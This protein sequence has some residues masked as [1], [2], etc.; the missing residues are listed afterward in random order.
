[1]RF[2]GNVFTQMYYAKTHAKLVLIENE[3]HNISI[4][5]SQNFTRGNREENGIV[6]NDTSVFVTYKTE[7]ERIKN[8]SVKYGI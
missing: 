2:A 4:V 1:M 8:H 6:M 5:G 7:I 3:L